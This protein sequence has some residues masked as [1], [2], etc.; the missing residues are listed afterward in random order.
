MLVIFDCDG[1]L[2]DSE[3]LSAEVLAESF[4]DA[5]REVSREHLL[6]TY[7]GKSVP[8]CVAI[9]TREL[10]QLPQNQHLSSEEKNALGAAFWRAMQ[11]QTLEACKT[12]LRAIP[13][14]QQ[15]LQ[16]LQA[17]AIPF[18]VASN[19]KHEKMAVTLA[20]TGLLPFVEERVFSFEEV[21]RG[22]PAP[23]LFL[24]AAHTL[25]A[26]PAATFVVEDSITGVQAALAAGM[27]PLA[28]C[29]AEHDGSANHLLPQAEALGVTHFSH[30]EQLLPL[31]LGAKQ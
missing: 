30:M 18:C 24:H 23:D 10:A 8:D 12:R 9:A 6:A 13:G 11:L 15:V 17:A 31:L 14:V 27:T 3:I 19:G 29:P 7:R 5:G 22:K 1:V 25:G 16:G 28:Y 4:R 26:A 21:A 2:V 20:V